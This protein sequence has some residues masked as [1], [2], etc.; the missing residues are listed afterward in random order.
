[1]IR[2]NGLAKSPDTYNRRVELAPVETITAAPQMPSQAVPHAP[3][4]D[5]SWE[6]NRG[7]L[8]TLVPASHHD[9]AYFDAP[10]NDLRVDLVRERLKCICNI[11]LLKWRIS[12]GIAADIM[13]IQ[14]GQS[15]GAP[16][17]TMAYL[18]SAH[19]AEGRFEV[20]LG[21]LERA[22]RVSGLKAI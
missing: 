19:E 22:Q 11:I 1:M 17:E 21:K 6:Y 5:L 16:N 3:E 7:W 14:A 15:N 13:S 10:K 2:G 9:Y 4:V 18:R 12:V 20:V 8:R